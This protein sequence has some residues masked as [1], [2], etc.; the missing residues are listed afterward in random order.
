MKVDANQSGM[1]VMTCPLPSS[2]NLSIYSPSSFTMH[3]TLN[4]DTDN[5]EN[6]HCLHNIIPCQLNKKEEEEYVTYA[7]SKRHT[8][9]FKISQK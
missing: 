2:R 7:N 1:S 3:K 8:A 4:K 6:D 9:V 5:N